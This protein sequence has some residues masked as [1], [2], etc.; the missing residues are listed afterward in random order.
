ML[1]LQHFS[2]C[3]KL[4]TRFYTAPKPKSAVCCRISQMFSEFLDFRTIPRNFSLKYFLFRRKFHGFLREIQLQEIWIFCSGKWFWIFILAMKKS[5]S[6]F[7]H[8]AT[9]NNCIFPKKNG[10]TNP[11]LELFLNHCVHLSFFFCLPNMYFIWSFFSN[12][13][14]D[15]NQGIESQKTGIYGWALQWDVLLLRC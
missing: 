7:W 5:S 3:T 2:I 12:S 6:I 1:I 9:F 4:L 13:G 11:P 8:K 15:W 14:Q 10:A